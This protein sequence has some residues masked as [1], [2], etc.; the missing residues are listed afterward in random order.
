MQARLA[1]VGGA[2]DFDSKLTPNPFRKWIWL[3]IPNPSCSN[4]MPGAVSFAGLLRLQ[5]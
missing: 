2:D 1:L 3:L 4:T 5:T